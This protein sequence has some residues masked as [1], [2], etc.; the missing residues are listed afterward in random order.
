M[1]PN[2]ISEIKA[3][4]QELFNNSSDLILHEF[5]TSLNTDTLV[6][7][8]NGL[9][10]KKALNDF[11]IKPLIESLNSPYD[12]VSTIYVTE[13]KEV[14]NINN[15][16]YEL[17]D[18]HVLLFHEDL[19]IAYVINLCR[20]EKRSVE[21]STS[22]Q[23]LRGPRESFIEDL[24]INKTL[25]RR[26][27]RNNNLVFE[28]YIFGEQ[29]NTR[30]SIVYIKG[31]VNPRILDELK[32]R[33]K[34]I[35][36]DA[37]LDVHYIEEYLDDSPNSFVCTMFNT[38]KPDVLSAKILE[39][40]IGIICDGSPNVL[41]VP[42]LF[43][44][45][46]MSAEDYYLRPKFCTY[47]R[48]LRFISFFISVLLAGVYVALV[49]FHQEMLPTQLIISI[50]GQRE[51][52]PLPSL[53]EAL[54]MIMFFE[55]MKEAGLRLPKPIGQT[56]TLIGG[57]VIGQA[58]VD[59]GLISAFMVIVVSA[60]GIAEFVN[61]SLRELIVI[62]RL[63]MIVL[64]GLL[65]LFGI[66]CGILIFI[67]HLISIKSF[68]VPFMFPV[69]PYDKEGMKDFL[70]RAPLRKMNYRP[71]YISDENTRKRNNT[72]EK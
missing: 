59:A 49:N 31:I 40:R 29:T 63:L 5:K 65:G 66:A 45:N 54:I 55:I 42:K 25:I 26:I 52:V 57:L 68:G 67:F 6:V 51:G 24:Y 56:V 53:L 27:I 50:A 47:L 43:I 61:P 15:V 8:I 33:L 32:A 62:Y 11:V 4:I 21:E 1:I 13:I 28:D 58:A 70:R 48:I 34:K 69:A 72:Y 9:I 22:E 60:T 64:G 12:I 19:E 39:G 7:Y 36:L 14:N 10:D 44:E 37:V 71:K 16:I 38:E 23:V 46:L 2:N 3:K 20:Y 30:V 17:V 41:T 18:G 35:K